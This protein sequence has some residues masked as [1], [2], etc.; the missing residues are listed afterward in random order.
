MSDERP[1]I[2]IVPLVD[3]ARESLWMLPGYMDGILEAG[4]TPVMLP[5]T[6]SDSV[7]SHVV[8]MCDGILFTGG[9]DVAPEVYGEE[10]TASYL[11]TN[12]ELSPERDRM[13]TV[14]LRDVLAVDKPILGI[15]RGI[16]F[17]NA[18]LGGTL[19]HDLP[20]EKP[21]DVE[22]H[23]KPPYD[24]FG[25][26]VNLI[27]GTPLAVLM[28]EAEQGDR[29]AVNS[30]HHQAVRTL[31][32]ALKPMATADDGIVEALY[33]PASRFCWAVQ[34][35]PE[36][37]HAVDERSRMIFSAFVAAARNDNRTIRHRSHH[38]AKTQNTH[39]NLKNQFTSHQS[40]TAE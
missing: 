14:L 31:A 1:L 32:P 40:S 35:H 38:L 28:A 26:S 2:G 9:Q 29:I 36:F 30:Y 17:I 19:W 12:P 33:R 24:Q 18:A 5:L 37:L 6:D 34:W 7:I 13:E 11:A 39:E 8:N 10:C 21:S 25:H 4:G 23:M 3:Y 22:H 15:C 20:T 16:Q 27:K